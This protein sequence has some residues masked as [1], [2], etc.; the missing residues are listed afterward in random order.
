M[1]AIVPASLLG[2]TGQ[3]PVDKG[4]S[5]KG[6]SPAAILHTQGGVSVNGYEATDS[7]AV[8]AGDLLETKPGFSATLN[9]E[10]TTI[11]VQEESVAK[12]QD[13]V[14]VLDHG[15]VSVGTSRSFKVRVNCITVIPVLNEWT[16]YEVSDVNG[17][18]HVSARKGDVRVELGV[19]P[20]KAPQPNAAS[21]ATVREGEQGNYRESD[22]CGA[23]ARPT[24]A[25]ST[26][27][28]KW[29]AGG[30]AGAGVLV[31]V[32]IHGG[33]GKTPLSSSQP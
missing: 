25:S 17:A 3:S 16:Q 6:Q 7:S 20:Q 13:E 30:A 19:N 23:P 14:L 12:L 15:S 9:L 33:G 18:V 22:A 21:N 29:I 32:L 4:Q 24:G 11:Q 10:G 2:Q 5:A 26:L 1:M 28:P 8:F 31:W 27:S